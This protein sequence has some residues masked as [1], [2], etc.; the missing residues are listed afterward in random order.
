MSINGP[1]VHLSP[2]ISLT[3]GQHVA[4]RA[5]FERLGARIVDRGT[6]VGADRSTP[7]GYANR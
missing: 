1:V 5:A 3:A 7:I 4:L 2:V 6:T